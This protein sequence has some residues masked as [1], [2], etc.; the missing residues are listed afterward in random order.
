VTTNII[1]GIQKQCARC[2]ELITQ[3]D[4]LVSVHR[5]AGPETVAFAK[6]MIQADINEGEAAIASG[7]VG[8]MVK[9]YQA[10]V[11]CK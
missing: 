6:T 8:R 1:E 5:V 4:R 11:D 10:L 3:Y 7:D 2:R 9:A